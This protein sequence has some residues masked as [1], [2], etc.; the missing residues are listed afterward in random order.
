MTTALRRSLIPFLIV[1]FGGGCQVYNTGTE[2]RMDEPMVNVSFE[3]DKAR[4][5]FDA[6]IHGTERETRTTARVGSP[7]LSAY[8]RTETVAFNAHCNDHVRAADRNA[9]LLITE[10]EA[11]D[12][13]RY[14]SEQGKI[15]E[16]R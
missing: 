3:N 2:T 14:L 4:E 6:I 1:A 13:Y 10:K 11:A 16:R 12:Y 8:S 7:S 9:D 5:L 15:R